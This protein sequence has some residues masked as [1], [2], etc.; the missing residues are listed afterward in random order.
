MKKLPNTLII[1]T[2][3]LLSQTQSSAF[4]EQHYGEHHDED[5]HD[6]EHH[7]SWQ[8]NIHRFH[9]Q[10]FN[11]WKNGRWIHARHGTTVGWW[12]VV[13]G[14]WYTY[15]KAIYPY[16]DPYTPPAVLVQPAPPVVAGPNTPAPEQVWYYCSNPQGYYPY[17]A[18]CQVPWQ[19]VLET[20]PTPQ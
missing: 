7:E 2:I 3:Y 18:Q 13:N 16:P 5:H 20:Q 15:P 10:D 14:V 11:T 12:W 8:G 4:A 1:M 19:K 17:I 9:E 6:H